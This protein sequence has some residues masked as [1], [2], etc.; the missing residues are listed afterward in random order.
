[1]IFTKYGYNVRIPKDFEKPFQPK[2][3]TKLNKSFMSFQLPLF[4]LQLIV[5]PNEKLNLHIFEP[6]YKQ[7]ILE[8][9]EEGKLFG[10]PPFINR[11]LMMMGTRMKLISI[12]KTYPNGEMDIRTQGV[13][14]FSIDHV[15]NP[16][17]EKLYIG[18]D[19]QNFDFDITANYLKSEKILT[20]VEE[21]FSL[22]AIP[23]DPPELTAQF[24]TY[25]IAHHIGLSLEQEFE[26]FQIP[27]EK[28]RQIYVLSHLEEI[29][30]RVKQMS[31]I[32]EKALMNGHFRNITPPEI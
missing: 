1:M 12:E 30:P 16:F 32:R 13:D 4:P 18:A 28:E 6:R 21:L 11:E 31:N 14:L 27:S 15:Y 2:C 3:I 5:F 25:E 10:I 17:P 29:L 20:L 9:H 23:K 8:C 26:F 19:V 24:S 22:L 7:L